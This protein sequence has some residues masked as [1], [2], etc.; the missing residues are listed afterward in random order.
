MGVIGGIRVRSWFFCFGVFV[1]IVGLILGSSILV[2]NTL[3]RFISTSFFVF[4]CRLNSSSLLFTQFSTS[5]ATHIVTNSFPHFED[6][7]TPLQP[8]REQPQQQGSK[9]CHKSPS[10]QNPHTS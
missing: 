6:R 4:C 7:L 8:Y 10:Y 2:R 9:T 1:M 5:S 3:F